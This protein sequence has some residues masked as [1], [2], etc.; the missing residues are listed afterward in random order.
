[1]AVE[2]VGSDL[3]PVVALLTAGVVAA[4]L[5]IRLGLGSILGYLTAGVVI[6]PFGLGL[7]REKEDVFHIAEF[8]IVLFLFIIGLELS[9]SRLWSLRKNIF[10]LGL[11]Q[12]LATGVIIGGLFVAIGNFP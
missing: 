6:G 12:M 2:A 3:V 5:F 10:G 11:A 1:M 9:L 4:A 7:L 8:G